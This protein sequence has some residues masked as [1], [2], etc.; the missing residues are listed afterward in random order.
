VVEL[1]GRSCL[2]LAALV[3]G[4]VVVAMASPA[5]AEQVAVADTALVISAAPGESNVL[6]VEPLGLAYQVTDDGADLTAGPGCTAIAVRLV[7][8]GGTVLS[9]DADLGDGDDLAGLWN[10]T[11][12]V[13]ITGG[14]GDD[15]IEGGSAPDDLSGGDGIDSLVGGAGPDREGGGQGD[16]LVAGDAGA[17][18]LDG[19]DGADIVTGDAGSGDVLLG[20]T[21]MDLVTG[22]AGADNL[23]GGGGNDALVGGA[24]TDTVTT[25][26]GTDDVFSTPGGA[27]HVDC[28][29]GDRLRGNR[30]ARPSSCGP[31]G[32]AKR[33]P[34]V[35]PP[36]PPGTPGA[37]AAGY[38][39]PDPSVDARVR[40]IGDAEAIS[41]RVMADFDGPVGLKFATYDRA[42]HRLARFDKV[43]RTKHWTT[44][45]H[46]APHRAA[47]AVK[48]KCCV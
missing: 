7:V 24:G 25:G 18:T 23:N 13:R 32:A 28:R 10:V 11:V 47:V 6:D 31:L 42:G 26:T 2:E 29:P 27:D 33:V 14:P 5:R 30:R 15:L 9:I 21:G 16:D 4:V 40:R 12:P 43:V 37:R 17:D 48:A 1:Q 45:R 35:W 36:L 39:P 19:G 22:G 41:V 46:P 34:T 8:C 20:G 38:V 44:F 3:A